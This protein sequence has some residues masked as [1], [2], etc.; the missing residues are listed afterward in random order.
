MA[1]QQT[2]SAHTPR[3]KAWVSRWAIVVFGLF[4][5]ATQSFVVQTHIHVGAAQVDF[6]DGTQAFAQ[7]LS[8][9][10]SAIAPTADNTSNEKTPSKHNPA[11]CEFCRELARS[12]QL[13]VS[14]AAVAVLPVFA[15]SRF[16]G[17]AAASPYLAAI[18]HGWQSRA[19]PQA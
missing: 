11:D 8:A 2:Q 12:G 4:A 5:M 6:A 3:Q 16:I 14:T 15:T 10:V 19:P 7:T 13:V 18:A 17:F 9:V 1:R